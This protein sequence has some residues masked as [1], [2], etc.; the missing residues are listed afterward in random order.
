MIT[1]F[2]LY[3]YHLCS[4]TQHSKCPSVLGFSFP[5][6]VPALLHQIKTNRTPLWDCLILK[7]RILNLSKGLF[8]FMLPYF[9]I[10]LLI[11]PSFFFKFY[12]YFVLYFTFT[13]LY[14]FCH[15]LTWVHHG[16][17]QAP[18]P[19]SPSH[20]PPHIITLDHPHAPAPSVLYPVSNIDWHFVSYTI[21]YMFQRHSPKSSHPLPVPQSP[22]W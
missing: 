7:L 21:V 22:K 14:W 5:F 1:D 12:Y 6:A 16:C 18:N 19:E 2:L 4:C 17:I 10:Y 15:T 20:L 11:L 13:I 8:V 9:K 3:S